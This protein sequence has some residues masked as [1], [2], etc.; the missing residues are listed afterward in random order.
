M[1]IT[2]AKGDFLAYKV[3]LVSLQL[4]KSDG[5]LVETL[6]ASTTVDFAQLIDVTEIL[7]A[8]QIPPGD[9]VA[10]QVTV[11]FTGATIMADDGTGTGVAVKPV[12]SSGAALGLLQL[13]VQLDNKNDLKINATK[14]SRVAFD[15]NLLASNMVNL[16]AKTDTVSPT[17]VADVVPIDNKQIRVRGEISAVDTANNDYTVNVDPFHDNDGNKLSPLVVDTTG[18]TTFEINGKPFAG[19]AGLAQLAALPADTVAVAF[20]NLQAGDQTFT[21]TSVL[22]GSSAEGGGFDHIVGNVVA[23][24]GNTL[25]IHGARMDGHDGNDNDDDDFIAGN[26]TVNVAAATAVTTEGQSSATPAH[27]IAEISVGSHIEAFGTATRDNSGEVILDAT[28]GRVRLDLTQVQGSLRGSGTGN[29][30]LNLN[31]IDRQP[32]SLFSFTGTGTDP[33][34]YVVA[35]GALNVSPFSVGELVSSIGFVNPFGKAPPD[36]KAVTVASVAMGCDSN[37]NCMCP[38]NSGGGNNN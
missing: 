29:I 1:T 38:D 9:Y 8:Q 12:N 32:V 35:T 33:T 26:S 37:N 20:G 18:S 25:T 11:D 14:A 7:S 24:N 36:F 22:A 17:L 31:S 27:T 30:T 34:K 10:A 2:D 28:A 3:K 4:K 19:A 13:M 21:A 6:P 15:F 23:R 16:T 5:T